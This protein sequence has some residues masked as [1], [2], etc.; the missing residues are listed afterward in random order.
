MASVLCG[1]Q[2]E[3]SHEIT[4]F[5]MKIFAKLQNYMPTCKKN[6]LN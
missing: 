4:N 2:D 6:L 1:N 3:H 5:F